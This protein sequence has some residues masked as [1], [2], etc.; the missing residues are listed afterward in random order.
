MRPRVLYIDDDLFMADICDLLNERGFEVKWTTNIDDSIEFLTHKGRTI[1]AIVMD[2]MM[3]PQSLS[4]SPV[5]TGLRL[6]ERIR[7]PRDSQQALDVAEDI[8]IIVVTGVSRLGIIEQARQAAGAENVFEKPFQP[9]RVAD[10]LARLLNVT[11]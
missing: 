6:I 1:D 5:T 2:L 7:S 8:P 4:G 10:A 11:D 3:A 9:E